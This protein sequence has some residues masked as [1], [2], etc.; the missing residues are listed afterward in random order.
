MHVRASF[1]V[2]WAKFGMLQQTSDTVPH[3]KKHSSTPWIHD[4]APCFSSLAP[5]AC[6]LGTRI[7][8]VREKIKKERL[9]NA[10]GE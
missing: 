2:E 10:A 9:P 5:A 3:V 7:W 8:P 6:R 4:A 1:G